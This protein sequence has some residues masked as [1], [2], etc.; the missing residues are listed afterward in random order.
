MQG[1]HL[2]HYAIALAPRI[3]F[4]NDLY[5]DVRNLEAS[6]ALKPLKIAHQ[7]FSL[8]KFIFMQLISKILDA[9]LSL[10]FFP[11]IMVRINC[12]SLLLCCVYLQ[13]DSL[14]SYLKYGL[15]VSTI[16]KCTEFLFMLTPWLELFPTI[17]NFC[18]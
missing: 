12:I 6:D 9:F 16:P 10:F 15:F 2:T 11:S 5:I 4:L 13:M 18:F 17:T 3:L 8:Y 1:K 14:R 7:R